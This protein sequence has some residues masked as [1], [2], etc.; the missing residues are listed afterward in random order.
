MKWF[1][2]II[3]IVNT[4]LLIQY[5]LFLCLVCWK[6]LNKTLARISHLLQE[7]FI[8][9]FLVFYMFYGSVMFA[10]QSNQQS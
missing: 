4:G 8:V 9:V 7:R 10:L 6:R 2:N 1:K 3:D 5:G